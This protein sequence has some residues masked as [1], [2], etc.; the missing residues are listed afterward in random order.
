M[1]RV[2]GLLVL[3]VC[4]A[5]FGQAVPIPAGWVEDGQLSEI[6]RTRS[7]FQ[8]QYYQLNVVVVGNVVRCRYTEAQP[9]K[10]GTLE[11]LVPAADLARLQVPLEL[12]ISK[13]SNSVVLAMMGNVVLAKPVV[14]V[15]RPRNQ[16]SQLPYKPVEN[17]MEQCFRAVRIGALTPSTAG[18]SLTK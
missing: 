15:F 4:V 11:L 9:E 1:C 12:Q 18:S 2:L 14:R 6:V 17:V 16:L 7:D 3:G 8:A 13:S 5:G 10:F